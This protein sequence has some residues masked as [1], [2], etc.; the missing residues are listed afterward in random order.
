[1]T[2]ELH[3]DDWHTVTFWDEEQCD[4]NSTHVAELPAAEVAAIRALQTACTRLEELHLHVEIDPLGAVTI[5]A[6]EAG[7]AALNAKGAA[8]EAEREE[9]FTLFPPR[10][11]AHD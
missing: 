6:G 9:T 10:I 4:V 7:H 3:A 8:L 2:R 1:M 5:Y 11:E